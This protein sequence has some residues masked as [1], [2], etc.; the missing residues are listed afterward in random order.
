[1]LL[2]LYSSAADQVFLGIT[3]PSQKLTGKLHV[4]IMEMDTTYLIFTFLVLQLYICPYAIVPQEGNKM[5]RLM[6]FGHLFLQRPDSGFN[7]VHL[8]NILNSIDIGQIYSKQL[9]IPSFFPLIILSFFSL[10]FWLL[11][12]PYAS[13][14]GT[15]FS[16]LG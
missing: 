4:D 1:L 12:C 7:N 14:C 2:A 11:P 9:L 16:A 10:S 5:K 8:C 13:H 6:F 3:L 15:P